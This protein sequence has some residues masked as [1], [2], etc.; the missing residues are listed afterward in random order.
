MAT[1][2]AR[3]LALTCKDMARIERFYTKHFGFTRA[4]VI[5]LGNGAQIIFIK[6][7]NLYLELF[8][9]NGEA[10]APPPQNDGYPWAGWR[11]LAF[12]VDNVDAK[13][14]EMGADAQIKLGP[15]SFDSFIQGW[16][17]AWIA[18]ASTPSTA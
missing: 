14:A 18:T 4:R 17:S 13:L 15:M 16:R 10:P 2:A 5:D 12:K 8:A 1:P 3:H 9:A 7:G 11:H 6:S